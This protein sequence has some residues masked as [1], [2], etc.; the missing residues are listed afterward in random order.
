MNKIRCPKCRRLRE[1]HLSLGDGESETIECGHCSHRF[2]VM[3]RV[4]IFYKTQCVK[5]VGLGPHS[6]VCHSCGHLME[7]AT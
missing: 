7:K 1:E 3:A 6:T 2:T 4:E 5:C